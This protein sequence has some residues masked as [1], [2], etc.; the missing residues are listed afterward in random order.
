MVDLQLLPLEMT[1]AEFF[2]GESLEVRTGILHCFLYKSLK[3]VSDV[4]R[5]KEAGMGGAE[6]RGC[7]GF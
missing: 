5:G 6:L 4:D 1:F 2:Q 7:Y 3:L